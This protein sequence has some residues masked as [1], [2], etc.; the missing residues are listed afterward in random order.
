MKRMM[1]VVGLIALT[2][3]SANAAQYGSVV[4]PEGVSYT[5][6]YSNNWSNGIRICG[7]TNNTSLPFPVAYDLRPNGAWVKY[8][9]GRDYGIN[10]KAVGFW[11]N[12]TQLVGVRNKYGSLN[13][14]FFIPGTGAIDMEPSASASS[15]GN[16]E[17]PGVPTSPAPPSQTNGA[18]LPLASARNR[19][20]GVRT[21]NG[22]EYLGTVELRTY[23][24]N[25]IAITQVVDDN[26][27]PLP[28]TP[29]DVT[30]EG[31]LAVNLNGHAWIMHHGQESDTF[32]YAW[33]GTI[34][35]INSR[36]WGV[37]QNASGNPVVFNGHQVYE[38]GLGS[39][40]ANDVNEPGVVI[41]FLN[42]GIG[43]EGFMDYN[44]GPDTAAFG[45]KLTFATQGLPNGSKVNAGF[46][47]ADNGVILAAATVNGYGRWA[48][49]FPY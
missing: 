34:N 41:G 1:S 17:F 9:D 6:L 10:G 36:G 8:Y 29:T 47:I 48:L 16:F 30:P 14:A 23:T 40:G 43:H 46:K 28:G 26:Q 7:F 42:E 49:L 15:T 12:G 44:A 13:G 31:D 45:A 39:G 19:I 3:V 4:L 32:Q 25:Q 21:N 5:A 38:I 35:A 24:E 2:Q 20:V 22:S 33:Q 27:H 37:G 11:E 18:F